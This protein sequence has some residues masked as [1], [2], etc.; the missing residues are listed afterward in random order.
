MQRVDWKCCHG[1]AG[2]DDVWQEH[3]IE[4]TSADPPTLDFFTANHQPS[5]LTM[6]KSWANIVGDYTSR[7]LTVPKDKLPAISAIA[8]AFQNDSGWPYLV[9]FWGEPMAVRLI[10]YTKRDDPKRLGPDVALAK[11][12]E[13]HPSRGRR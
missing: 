6:V 12:T 5:E 1:R 4:V 2:D 3:S 9:S 10:W 11:P 13:H 7:F 8:Q